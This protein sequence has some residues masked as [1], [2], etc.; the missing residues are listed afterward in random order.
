MT[1]RR[2]YTAAIG[3]GYHSRGETAPTAKQPKRGQT[4][5]ANRPTAAIGG[6]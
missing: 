1:A 3:G 2:Q 5:P 4:A 6:G